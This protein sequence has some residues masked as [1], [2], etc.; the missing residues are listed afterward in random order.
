[1]GVHVTGRATHVD[2][3]ALRERVATA[4]HDKYSRF[5]T[6]REQMPDATRA[7]YDTAAGTIE[8]VADDRMLS[9]DNARLFTE[10]RG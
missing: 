9:W 6:A 3:A 4:L 1:V 2:D 8:I 7:H 5:R 10:E